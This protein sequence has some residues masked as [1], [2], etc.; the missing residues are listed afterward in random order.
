MGVDNKSILNDINFRE[1]EK[2]DIR[3]HVNFIYAHKRQTLFSDEI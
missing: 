3:K 1:S 2:S